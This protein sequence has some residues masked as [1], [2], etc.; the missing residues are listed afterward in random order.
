MALNAGGELDEKS[1]AVLRSALKLH[2]EDWDW[3]DATQNADIWLVDP[4]VCA[5]PVASIDIAGPV[6]I[7]IAQQLPPTIQ[8]NDLYLLAPPLRGARLLKLLDQITPGVHA[9]RNARQAAAQ[10]PA[11]P[12]PAPPDAPDD[13]NDVAPWV[14]QNIM[15]T[16]KTNL[17]RF[18]VTAELTVWLEAMA[19]GPVSYD[20]MAEDLEMDRELLD[21][22][23][24]AVA[25]NGNL[26][27]EHGFSL[28]PYN[29]GGSLLGK[30]LG[31]R[32]KK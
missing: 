3:V 16:G 11:E 19:E 14:G 6:V 22:V 13:D 18:P 1:T 2:Q 29:K 25:G 17:S 4:T 12:D 9:R 20:A 31:R 23:L 26:I 7:V 10:A 21:S 32:N 5:D 24:N 28:Q 8:S 27:D 15:L 30:M